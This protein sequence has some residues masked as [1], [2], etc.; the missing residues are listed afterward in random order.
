MTSQN[1]APLHLPL[2][3]VFL[4]LQEARANFRCF[5]RAYLACDGLYAVF[6]RETKH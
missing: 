1:N 5:A 3:H 2:V 4:I 6:K